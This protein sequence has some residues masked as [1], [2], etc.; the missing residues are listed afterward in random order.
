[1]YQLLLVEDDPQIREVIS[2]Y[3]SEK[4][5][6]VVELH[7]AKDGFEGLHFVQQQEF[8]LV[9]LDIMMPGM[10]GFSLC[11]EIRRKSI[12]PI[13]FLTARNQEEDL[14]YGY[15]I[16]CDDYMVKPFS[17]AALYAKVEALLKRAK[18]LVG[19]QIFQTGKI[20]LN[21]VTYEVTAE[22]KEISLAPKEYALLKFFM[23]HKGQVLSR[24]TLLDH[25]WGF[26]YM[27]SD[28]VVDNHVKKL[29]KALGSSG[30]LIKTVI[31]Q[32]YRMEEK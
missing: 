15:Q 11:K 9:M 20:R 32:G 12:V 18:G 26:S 21:P 22:G 10:D 4:R 17:I 1:M 14:L 5:K 2:D 31:T 16:G 8:D 24:N 6:G 23:E 30:S 13:I 28:R 25:V 27:G 7:M 19:E 29:R 3:F